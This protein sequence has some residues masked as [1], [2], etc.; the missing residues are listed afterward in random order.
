VA[1]SSLDK[2]QLRPFL[3]PALAHLGPRG[4]GGYVVPAD[5]ISHCR[6]L[7]SLGLCDNWKFDKEFLRLNPAVSIVGVDHTVGPAFFISGIPF[8][9]CKV[10]G[11]ALLFNR[12]KLA[13]YA[14]RLR[15][16]LEY[17]SF[18]REP[19]KHLRKRVS[20]ASNSATD[21]TLNAILNTSALNGGHDVFLKMDIEGS[22]YEIVPDIIK[23]HPR[24]RCL[25]VEFH[26]LHK[27]TEEFNQAVRALA[28][29]FSIVHIHGNNIGPYDQTI[30]FPITV[31]ITWI[32]KDILT[33]ELGPSTV[34]YPREGLD[35]P[36]TP[37]RPDYRLT[38]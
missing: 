33:E 5:Q 3:Y 35:F 23:N 6:L 20:A 38:L 25:V 30:D 1:I 10:F 26:R 22:E 31:E 8:C 13:K 16:Y 12:D 9:L 37:T 2:Q 27:R 4:D 28:R 7:I 21:I 29:H 24:I 15:A 19:H 32:N 34:C 17:F 36:N 11:Y 14:N 18:F